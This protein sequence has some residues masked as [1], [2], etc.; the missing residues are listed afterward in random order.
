LLVLVFFEEGFPIGLRAI[1]I[2]FG[3]QGGGCDDT[4]IRPFAGLA[5]IHQHRLALSDERSRCVWF[6]FRNLRSQA[7]ASGDEER[8]EESIYFH[9]EMTF[10]LLA[11]LPGRPA[12]IKAEGMRGA[13]WIILS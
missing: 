12:Q 2:T 8:S 9:G 5:D 1:E 7:K 13:E 4:S 3:E 6:Y 10:T 11:V